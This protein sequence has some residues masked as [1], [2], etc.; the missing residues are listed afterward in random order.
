MFPDLPRPPQF[1]RMLPQRHCRPFCSVFI[2]HS[3]SAVLFLLLRPS[4]V[5]FLLRIRSSFFRL[6]SCFVLFVI[7]SSFFLRLHLSCFLL[8]PHAFCVL[9]PWYSSFSLILSSP[10]V[11]LILSCFVFLIASYYS[12][13]L[14]YF[15]V[16]FIPSHGDTVSK[17]GSFSADEEGVVDCVAAL[18]RPNVQ[19][20]RCIWVKCSS[21]DHSTKRNLPHEPP[22][23][24]AAKWPLSALDCSCHKNV[25]SEPETHQSVAN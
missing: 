5:V 22:V 10:S 4:F 9:L 11:F 14:P 18:Q 17:D 8:L 7:P 25:R 24:V 2:C 19:A 13:R 12:L 23:S 20:V 6:R 15:V 3:S 16:V 1:Q 21:H